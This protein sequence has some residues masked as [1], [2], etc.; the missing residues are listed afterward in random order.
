M[1]N[2]FISLKSLLLLTASKWFESFCCNANR[3]TPLTTR[4]GGALS[5]NVC[6]RRVWFWHSSKPI[7]TSYSHALDQL[8]TA[9][10]SESSTSF[11]GL[12]ISVICKGY[13]KTTYASTF[14]LWE[15]GERACFPLAHERA[16][17]R[18]VNA[19]YTKMHADNQDLLK[20]TLCVEKKKKPLLYS[21]YSYWGNTLLR[22]KGEN[23]FCIYRQP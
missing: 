16:A 22:R 10:I 19:N 13:L 1:Q 20:V 9:S 3:E 21:I 4:K 8:A 17:M 2:T 7:L 12:K 6:S 5:I 15:V 11:S 14:L 23:I 18:L